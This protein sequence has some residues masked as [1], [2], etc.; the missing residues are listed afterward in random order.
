MGIAPD[1]FYPASCTRC[2]RAFL[3]P[4]QVA[5]LDIALQPEP[6]VFRALCGP[7]LVITAYTRPPCGAYRLGAWERRRRQLL[8]SASQWSHEEVQEATAIVLS[9]NH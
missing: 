3:N 8:E 5:V 9:I 7:C 4:G 2:G 6:H 1:L